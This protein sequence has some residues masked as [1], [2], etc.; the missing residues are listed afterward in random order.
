MAGERGV[1]PPPPL[2]QGGERIIPR[3]EPDAC[4]DGSDVVQMAP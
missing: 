3:G 4:A 2:G 1:E